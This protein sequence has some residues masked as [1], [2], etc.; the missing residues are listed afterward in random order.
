MSK[1]SVITA[2]QAHKQGLQPTRKYGYVLKITPPI[3]YISKGQDI[4]GIGWVPHW[5][6][7]K[8]ITQHWQGWYKYKQDAIKRAAE[9]NKINQKT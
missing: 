2:Y 1:Y 7:N 4:E 6:G 5:G 3:E 8:T 9:L